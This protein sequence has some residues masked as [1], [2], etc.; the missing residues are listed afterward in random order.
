MAYPIQIQQQLYCCK[1][2]K[3]DEKLRKKTHG[4][5]AIVKF[6]WKRNSI[7][8]GD[9]S[10]EAIMESGPVRVKLYMVGVDDE[11]MKFYFERLNIFLEAYDNY[12]FNKINYPPDEIYNP[13]FKVKKTI[14]GEFEVGYIKN[15]AKITFKG[16]DWKNP[17]IEPLLELY[18]NK[19]DSNN[20]INKMIISTW[21]SDPTKYLYNEPI[22]IK[23]DGDVFDNY[24]TYYILKRYQINQFEFEHCLL[25]KKGF[26]KNNLKSNFVMFYRNIKDEKY[27]LI[28]FYFLE[29]NIKGK[30]EENMSSDEFIELRKSFNHEIIIAEQFTISFHVKKIELNF[31]KNK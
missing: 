19:N 11:F 13:K 23:G 26:Y 15:S 29:S 7:I 3:V 24:Q 25:S 17:I 31:L 16:K 12:D 28:L 30:F 4:I 21:S 22:F 10:R 5:L 2:Q 9:D 6:P 18:E 27:K 1:T 14:I 8:E 20:N